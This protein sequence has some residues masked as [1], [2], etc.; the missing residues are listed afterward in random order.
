M[1]MHR[2]TEEARRL[3]VPRLYLWTYSAEKLYDKLGWQVVERTNYFGKEVVVM[4][5]DLSGQ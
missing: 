4:Q 5:V 2:A 1:L 3:S